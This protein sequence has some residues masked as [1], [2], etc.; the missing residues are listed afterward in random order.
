MSYLLG[1]LLLA[2]ASNGSRVSTAVTPMEKVITLMEKLQAQTEAEGKEEAKQYDKA[3]CY[4]K[5]QAS[6]KQYSKEQQTKKIEKLTTEIEELTANGDKTATEIKKMGE[7]IDEKKATIET[8]TT[9]RDEQHEKYLDNVRKDKEMLKDVKNSIEAMKKAKAFMDNGDAIFDLMKMVKK[10]LDEEL[11]HHEEK[12]WNQTTAFDKEKLGLTKEI[13]FLSKGKTEAEELSS[14]LAEKKED[15]ETSR[16]EAQEQLNSDNEFLAVLTEDCQ[17]KAKDYDDRSSTRTGELQALAEALRIIKEGAEA[18]YG[19]NKKLNLAQKKVSPVPAKVAV[20]APSFIQTRSAGPRHDLISQS[21][22]Q[23]MAK[24]ELLQ[25]LKKAATKL[26]SP[27]LSILSVKIQ[28]E[29]DPFGKVRGM[30][31]DMVT[32]LE[33]ESSSEATE[34][35]FCDKQ[36]SEQISKRDEYNGKME[37]LLARISELTAAIAKDKEDKAELLKGRQEDE[38]ALSEATQ[39]RAA[40][41]KENLRVIEDT[42]QGATAVE[43]AINVLEKFYNTAGGSDSSYKGNQGASGG[44]LG[45]LQVILTDFQTNKGNTEQQEAEQQGE[46]DTLKAEYEKSIQEKKDLVFEAEG[47][48]ANNDADLMDSKAELKTTSELLGTTTE[49]LAGLKKRCIDAD[50][51]YEERVAKREQEI[52][53]CKNAYRILDNWEG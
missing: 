4:C 13:E 28:A 9:K 38:T 5:E 53:A 48:L 41:K 43:N 7:D 20:S 47:R 42:T 16:D 15:A 1:L 49:M 25:H 29:A 8:M 34:K 14:S 37:S 10:S 33:N 3:A 44:I 40:S 2:G 19:S 21:E 50:E 32:E 51:S 12:E 6:E 45:L 23:R 11:A 35:E 26:Q 18:N 39:E 36:M 27:V 46:Y 30:I 22:T 24:A 52:E 17:N 31:K